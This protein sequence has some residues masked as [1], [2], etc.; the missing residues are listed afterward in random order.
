MLE[1]G[2]NI[3]A[4]IHTGLPGVSNLWVCGLQHPGG[5]GNTDQTH[6]RLSERNEGRVQPFKDNTSDE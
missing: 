1:L 6:V 2:I 5:K 4:Y 3:H